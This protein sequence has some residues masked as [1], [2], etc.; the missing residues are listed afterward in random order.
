MSYLRTITFSA[1][2]L[3]AASA[4]DAAI[5]YDNTGQAVFGTD[6]ISAD[7]PQY[8]SFSTNASGTVSAIALMLD[9]GILPNANGTVDI[10]LYDDGGTFPDNFVADLGDVMDS[11]LGSSPSAFILDNLGLTLSPNTRYWISL[12]DVTPNGD[13]SSSIEWSYAA[14]ASGTSVAGEWN[15]NAISGPLPNGDGSNGT[16]QP[17]IMAVA[18]SGR[19]GPTV[20]EPASLTILGL[21]LAGL[22]LFRTRRGR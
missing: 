10:A 3:C 15:D 17:Y 9:S 22:G 16:S 7:G 6:P 19:L 1:L 20:P 4:A 21:G 18:S 5:L 2:A 13:G 14:D 11:Q 12:S 8:N